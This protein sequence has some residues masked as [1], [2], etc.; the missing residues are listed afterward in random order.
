MNDQELTF[1]WPLLGTI[2]RRRAVLWIILGP[3]LAA[4]LLVIL[5]WRMPPMFMSTAS[6]SLQQESGAP[7]GG[8]LAALSG[9]SGSGSKS[10]VGVI[11]S[12]RFAAEAAQTAGIQQ[13]YGFADRENATALVQKSVALDDRND[14]LLYLSVTLPGPSRL[15]PGAA[16][17]ER[18]VREA[19]KQVTDAYVQALSHYLRTTNSNRGSAL[20]RQAHGQL[21]EA[22]LAYN[23]AVRQ[24]MGLAVADMPT[25]AAATAESTSTSD[26]IPSGDTHSSKTASGLAEGSGIGSGLQQLYISRGQLAAEIQAA[27]AAQNATSQIASDRT[28][29]LTALPAEDPL[30][31]EARGQVRRA[32]ANLQNLRIDL[33]DD[34]PDVVAAR[35]RLEQAQTRLRLQSQAL[36]KGRTSESVQITAMQ[37]KYAAITRQINAAER[38]FKRGKKFGAV[39]EEQRNEVM[40]RLEVYKTA[41]T[42]YALLSMQTVAG[43]NMMD[44]IDEGRVPDSGKPG[45]LSLAAISLGTVFLLLNFWLAIEYII[46]VRQQSMHQDF[47]TRQVVNEEH[48]Q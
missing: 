29:D 38:D 43:T 39:L 20:L 3:L 15:S 19:T 30:L 40:L 28:D 1:D 31:A 24:M 18:E 4:A 46:R 41:A 5:L 45:T 9:L 35:A 16:G 6:I 36:Q 47:A 26:A 48:F 21:N 27:T 14:G 2:V 34:N 42:Q 10:Y 11:R 12:R 8:A 44:I 7:S 37:A 22:R 17:R 13:V 33:S 25:A 23:A 32:S